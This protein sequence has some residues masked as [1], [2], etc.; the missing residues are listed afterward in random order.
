MPTFCNVTDDDIRVLERFFGRLRAD[1]DVVSEA[2]PI[3]APLLAADFA[4]SQFV[5]LSISARQPLLPAT[6][7]R[8]HPDAA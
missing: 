4:V 8:V 1:A 2:P 7:R 6:R 5:K 3:A